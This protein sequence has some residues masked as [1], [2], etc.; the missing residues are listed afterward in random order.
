MQDVQV[1][2]DWIVAGHPK[3]NSERK[4]LIE[5]FNVLNSMK[6]HYQVIA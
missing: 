2:I 6:Q 3:F 4:V 1:V 5:L